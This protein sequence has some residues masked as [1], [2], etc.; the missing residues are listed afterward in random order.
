L[1]VNSQTSSNPMMR[2]LVAFSL[3]LALASLAAAPLA[4]SAEVAPPAADPVASVET[5]PVASVETS[6]GMPA[7]S[8]LTTLTPLPA[9]VTPPA[10]PAKKKKLTVRQVIAQAGRKAGLSTKEIAALIWIC[11]RE[12][13]FHPTSHSRSGYHGLFQLSKGMA[14]GRPW[15]N[16][17]WNT[18]RAIRYMRGRYGGVLKAK[19][20]WVAHHW[21]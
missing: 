14:H 16:P 5:T 11:K 3:T 4:A 9:P 6:A 20:F 12:S 15:K 8:S 2:G 13:N 17:A 19:A 21:Y 10:P 1:K 7:L 18:K